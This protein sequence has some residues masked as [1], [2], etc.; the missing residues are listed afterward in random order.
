MTRLQWNLGTDLTD[1]EL[2]ASG[3]RAVDWNGSNALGFEGEHCVPVLLRDPL[4]MDSFLIEA[5][6]ACTA[7]SFAGLVFGAADEKNFELVYVSASNEWGLPNLQYD[8]VMNGS[9]TWQIYHGPSYQ[10][11]AAVPPDQWVRIAVRVQPDSASIYVGG[12]SQPSLVIPN[13]LHGRVSGGKVGLWGSAPSTIR[14]LVVAQIEPRPHTERTPDSV[15]R[16]APSVVPAWMVSKLPDQTWIE[17]PVEINGTLNLN[18]L[19]TAEQ[20]AVVQ[21]K[22]SINLAE[23]QETWLRLGFSDRI[24]LW[25]NDNEVYAGEWKWEAP[26]FTMDGRIRADQIRVP[27][28][29]RAGSN[30]ILAEVASIEGMY[31][32][33]LSVRMGLK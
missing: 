17:A 32:W 11:V 21:A 23:R 29:W 2:G 4:G 19:Y 9:S 28:Q 20:G 18:R 25:V 12:S 30:T 16:P 14:N 22:Y 1:F 7:D 6:V 24:R 27:V 3:A 13:L 33:G 8:P 31:G 5:E 26:G 15:V 10:A